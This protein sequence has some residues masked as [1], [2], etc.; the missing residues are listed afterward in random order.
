MKSQDP[1]FPGEMKTLR[2]LMSRWTLG[3]SFGD[4]EA[5]VTTAEARV[6]KT[7]HMMEGE[8]AIESCH[9]F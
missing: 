9:G 1:S 7:L 3:D 8:M 2:G 6:S 5:M 4:G